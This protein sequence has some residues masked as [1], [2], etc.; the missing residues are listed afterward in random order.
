MSA[1]DVSGEGWNLLEAGN[2]ALA[3]NSYDAMQLA[4]VHISDYLQNYGQELDNNGHS[5]LVNQLGAMV[6]ALVKGE[7]ATYEQQKYKSPTKAFFNS[8]QGDLSNWGSD[9]IWL[10][11]GVAVVAL[12]IVLLK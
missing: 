3:K 2:L 12:I 11:V 1:R 10:I 7:V 6:D 8:L 9:T 4:A 5:N